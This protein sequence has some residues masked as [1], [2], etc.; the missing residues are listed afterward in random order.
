V[1]TPPGSVMVPGNGGGSSE[2]T[3]PGLP[4]E[5]LRP[6]ARRKSRTVPTV[7]APPARGS[8]GRLSRWH[9]TSV[10][11]APATSAAGRPLER[12]SGSA[13]DGVHEKAQGSIGLRHVAT[14][15]DSNGLFGGE[16]PEAAVTSSSSEP[17]RSNGERV[18]A[19]VRGNF[20]SQ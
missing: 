7:T 9:D 1:A 14:R 5:R 20:G 16:G 13:K 18:G 19:S 6:R 12:S 8:A 15:V 11:G 4:G 3:A 2:P 10:S 17:G